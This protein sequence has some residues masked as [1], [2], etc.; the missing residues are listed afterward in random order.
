MG[1]DDRRGVKRDEAD[2]ELYR[3]QVYF[4]VELY[5]K[6]KEG[7]TLAKEIGDYT[8]I[9]PSDVVRESLMWWMLM[10]H[11]NETPPPMS[12]KQK[13]KKKTYPVL[14]PKSMFDFY[15]MIPDR[16]KSE[17]CERIVRTYLAFKDKTVV[18]YVPELKHHS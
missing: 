11:R 3:I 6:I 18:K 13:G 10:K 15:K 16:A 8:Y 1:F 4:P 2:D 17:I 5:T 14:L 7:I 12:Q 9:T